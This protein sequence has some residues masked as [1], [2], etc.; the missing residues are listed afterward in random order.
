MENALNSNNELLKELKESRD[1]DLVSIR[2]ASVL[3]DTSPTH[4]YELIKTGK[5]GVEKRGTMRV[6]KREVK[7]YFNKLKPAYI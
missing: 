4:I 1:A 3:F 2:G 7:E 5:I 6:S